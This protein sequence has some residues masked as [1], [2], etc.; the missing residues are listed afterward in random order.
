[1]LVGAILFALGFFAYHGLKYQLGVF[2]S[3]LLI[4][5][6]LVGAIQIGRG[7]FQWK[8][9]DR[10]SFAKE[11]KSQNLFVDI[12]LRDQD[13]TL[14]HEVEDALIEKIRDSSTLKIELHSVDTANSMGTIHL[15]GLEADAMFAHI[16]SSLA[17][18]ALP[19][20]LRLF[21]KPGQDID[22]E[23]HGKRVLVNLPS[24]ELAR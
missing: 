2:G 19:G 12:P 5:I 8:Y 9:A 17:P 23:I 18:F 11:R 13:L 7:L 4:A 16:Y 24:T 3:Y 10:K 20:G 21:P 14:L 15:I 1:M 22:T 6:M